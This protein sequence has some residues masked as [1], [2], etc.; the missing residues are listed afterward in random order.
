MIIALSFFA[1][2]FIGICILFTLVALEA[3][4]GRR[5]AGAVRTR[6][7][8]SAVRLKTA[9]VHSRSEV[10]R[11]LPLLAVITR[12]CVHEAALGA[13]SL[14]RVVEREAH[15]IAD[16]VSH[17]YRFERRESTNQFL[18]QV[19]ESKNGNDSAED[20]SKNI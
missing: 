16:L 8:S 2:S 13:A 6:L 14:A 10:A 4:R 20:E 3:R 7:D 9:L 15:R 17:K 1:A 5:Y 19:S 11:I 12:W 18:H